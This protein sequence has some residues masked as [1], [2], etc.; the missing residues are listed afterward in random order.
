[1]SYHNLALKQHGL[2]MFFSEVLH[3]PKVK[4]VYLM[5]LAA[6]YPL[7]QVAKT[8]LEMTLTTVYT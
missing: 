5:K 3:Y 4:K 7:T 8:S 1:M 6:L 2:S